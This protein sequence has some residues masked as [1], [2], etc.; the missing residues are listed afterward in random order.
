MKS[1]GGVSGGSTSIPGFRGEVTYRQALYATAGGF[2]NKPSTLSGTFNEWRFFKNLRGIN[3][4]FGPSGWFTSIVF[5]DGWAYIETRLIGYGDNNAVCYIDF[6][7]S[8][9]NIDSAPFRGTYTYRFHSTTYVPTI[10]YN[11]TRSL[12][13]VYVRTGMKAQ[14]LTDTEWAKYD[15]SIF[16]EFDEL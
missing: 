10:T 9:Q 1:F 6:P 3:M 2:T 13:K 12:T 16:E 7:E 5:P 8:I 14:F 4:L 11:T 15:A